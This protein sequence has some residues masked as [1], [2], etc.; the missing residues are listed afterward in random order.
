MKFKRP[1]FFSVI[2]GVFLLAAFL[3]KPTGNGEKDAILMQTIR[4]FL[5]QLHY[6]PLTFDDNFSEKLYAE[7]LDGLDGGR[8]FLTQEDLLAFADYRTQLDD[9]AKSGSFEFFDRSLEHFDAALVK[10]QAYYREIL[11]QPFNFDLKESFESDPE[12]RG[13]AAND[14]ELKKV[15]YHLL[16]YETMTR[17]ADKMENQEKEGEET[18]VKSFAELEKEARA[19]VLELYNDWFDRMMKMK[20]DDRRSLYFNSLT[21]LFDPHTEFFEP[22]EKQ[23]FDIRFSGRLEGIGA[24]LQTVGDYTKVSSI[25]VGGPA[26]KTKEIFENDI[27]LKVAQG[28]EGEF[29]DVTGMVINDVVQLIRGKKGTL[30]RLLVKKVDGTTKEIQIIRDIVQLEDGWARSLIIDSNENE[31]IGYLN[32]PSFYAD[33]NDPNG[34]FCARDVNTEIEKLKAEKVN[35]IILDLRNN[36]GGSLSDVVRMT[37]FFLETGPIVQIKSRDGQTDVLRDVD[38]R[39]Q[40]D[41]PLIVLVNNFSASAS[42]IMAGALQD[43]GRAIIVGTKSTYGKGT[44]QRMYDLDMAVR[45]YDEIKPLGDIKITTQKFY[46]ITGGSNQLTG[47]IPDIILPD[48]YHFVDIGEREDAHAMEWTE[49]PKVDFQQNTYRIRKMDEIKKRSQQRVNNDPLFQK[50]YSRAKEVKEQRETSTYSLNLQDYV[51]TQKKMTAASNAFRDLFK[52]TFVKNAHNLAADETV[53][54]TEESSKARN[55]DFL[56]GV[57]KD[58]Y[59]RETM[60]IMHDMIVLNK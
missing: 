26:W 6:R 22:V 16:K 35:G 40:Y 32:L 14:A 23:N 29:K 47:V 30:V 18:P 11:S 53:I 19:S 58:I 12:K 44:V 38:S 54:N 7:Y 5:D 10:T 33:F 15:W 55:E 39:V 3:P 34:R 20:R 51:A 56:K 52:D 28:N 43:Y 60:N 57:A 13:Y 31:R 49:I 8:R 46:R 37:G 1:L 48:Q 21:H 41:G 17:L 4:V 36:G 2:L 24:T 42:E 50:I 59:L 25:V 27:I 9:E 45:G